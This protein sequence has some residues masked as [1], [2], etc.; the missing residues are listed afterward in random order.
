MLFSEL[1]QI[2]KSEWDQRLHILRISDTWKWASSPSPNHSIAQSTEVPDRS[3]LLDVA[4]Y[5]EQFP[6]TSCSSHRQ[7][8]CRFCSMR[9]DNLS[10]ASQQEWHPLK[11]T[12]GKVNSTNIIPLIINTVK[13]WSPLQKIYSYFLQTISKNFKVLK[14]NK[15]VSKFQREY[16]NQ[17]KH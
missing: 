17:T 3:F 6:A 13:K 10:M 2:W 14:Q 15:S 12:I 4:P 7:C 1:F 11:A 5:F 9:T 8:S 16:L